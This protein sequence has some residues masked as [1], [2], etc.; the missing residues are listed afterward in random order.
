MISYKQLGSWFA[1]VIWIGFLLLSGYLLTLDYQF[2]PWFDRDGMGA[3][4]FRKIAL[5]AY[6]TISLALCVFLLF[7]QRLFLG[8]YRLSGPYIMGFVFV[9]ISL[10]IKRTELSSHTI[11]G[12]LIILLVSASIL[13]SGLTLIRRVK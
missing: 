10:G 1:Q 7:L 13:Y 3:S 11:G 8:S 6:A 9:I 5:P 12:W 4:L 2:V